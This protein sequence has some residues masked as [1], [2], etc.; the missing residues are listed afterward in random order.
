MPDKHEVWWHCVEAW[1]ESGP[2]LIK[3][4]RRGTNVAETPQQDTAYVRSNCL[5]GGGMDS[6]YRLRLG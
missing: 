3:E 2:L 6:V 4:Y 1:H 5:K